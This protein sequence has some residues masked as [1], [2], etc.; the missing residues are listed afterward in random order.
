MRC[1]ALVVNH[2]NPWALAQSIIYIIQPCYLPQKNATITILC[3]CM[4]QKNSVQNIIE[5]QEDLSDLM[6]LENVSCQ[7]SKT[8]NSLR[9]S[10]HINSFGNLD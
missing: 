9:Y 10:V 2:C 4:L 5:T 8:L 3:Q 7:I 1:L 6:T